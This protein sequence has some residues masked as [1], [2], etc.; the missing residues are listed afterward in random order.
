ML[1]PEYLSLQGIKN[2]ASRI[3]VFTKD[4]PAPMGGLLSQ[5]IVANGFHRCINNLGAT[6]EA[7]GSSLN[8]VIEVTIYMA[9]SEKFARMNEV[10]KTYWGD[11]KPAGT[12]VF[13][14]ELPPKTLLGMKCVGLV[15][16]QSVA[17]SKV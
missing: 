6:L 17:K 12:T 2:M 11:I 7:A 5:G 13:M 8:D 14:L 16:R 1:R 3:P 9:S 10:Y 15:T 4:A